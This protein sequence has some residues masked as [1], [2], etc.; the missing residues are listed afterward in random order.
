MYFIQTGA[1]GRPQR[2][3]VAAIYREGSGAGI[4][5]T[6]ICTAR[7][8]LGA[9]LRLPRCL[10]PSLYRQV[11]S[12][13]CN[14]S[15]GTSASPLRP[16][17]G[18]PNLVR[19]SPQ[20]LGL[21]FVADYRRHSVG[22]SDEAFCVVSRADLLCAAS[23]AAV[24]Y[25]DVYIWRCESALPQFSRCRGDRRAVLDLYLV[26]LHSTRAHLPRTR[27]RHTCEW[28]SCEALL[29]SARCSTLP[30]FDFTSSCGVHTAHLTCKALVSGSCT[31]PHDGVPRKQ[32]GIS[33][34]LRF[35]CHHILERWCASIGHLA[36]D[37]LRC[38]YTCRG[39]GLSMRSSSC[40]PATRPFRCT[41]D[42]VVGLQ[43]RESEVRSVVRHFVADGG[44]LP[45]SER[46]CPAAH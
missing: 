15:S 34:H 23:V 14:S 38:P 37:F 40:S 43:V 42:H 20:I 24:S 21:P 2:K 6:T 27:L 5:A 31:R 16:L 26:S 17:C 45:L 7:S 36:H 35:G 30:R 13:P 10:V 18:P 12:A 46:V 39:Q 33:L 32:P 9:G 11:F 3:T 41:C 25:R 1:E 22:Y 28:H 4:P 44:T 8:W 29:P 19:C